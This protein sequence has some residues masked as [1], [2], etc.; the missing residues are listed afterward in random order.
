MGRRP[1]RRGTR[2]READGQLTRLAE[3]LVIGVDT[4]G[5]FT[6]ISVL[7]PDG[8][9]VLNKAPTTPSD[10]SQGVL[11]ALGEV[12]AA[13]EVTVQD[14]LAA[15]RVLKH[16]TT[17]GTNA[18]IT[19]R[20]PRIGFLTTRG[21]E[22]TP[23]IMR[24]VGR[25]DGLP[26]RERKHMSLVRKP[27]PLVGK[28]RIRGVRERVDHA[29]EVV[30]A[31]NEDDVR[32][33]LRHLIEVEQVEAIAV[34]LLF[35]WLNPSHEQAIERIADEQYGDRNLR[36]SYS[37]QLAP[38]VREY[39][40]GNTVLVDAFLGPTMDQYLSSLES[41]LSDQGFDGD[42]M[43]MQAN[44][45]ISGLQETSAIGTLSSGPAGGVMG[46]KYVASRLGHQNVITTDMGGTSF[47]VGL[48]TGGREQFQRDPLADRFRVIQ[49]MI[50]V[51]SIGA[52]GGTIAR[53][54]PVTQRLL[55]GPDSAGAEPG[56]ACY[57]AGG[58]RPTITDADLV[59]GYLD[60][61]FFWGGRRKLD[62]ELA[63]QAIA[64]QVAQPLGMSVT[65]A[66][67]GI[68]ELINHQ[69]SNLIRKKVGQ[70]GSSPERFV[71]YAFGGA[72][73]VH[74]AWY[75]A[76]LGV[77]Q[78]YNFAASP[79][80]SA[81]GIATSD[82]IHSQL[83]SFYSPLPCDCE[84]LNEHIQRYREELLGVMRREGAHEGQVDFVTTFHMRYRGQ[85]NELPVVV[86]KGPYNPRDL[87]AIV[88]LFEVR[89]ED[90]YGKG[91][92]YARAGVELVSIAIDA[93]LGTV[94]PELATAETTAGDPSPKAV[95]HAWSVANQDFV[96][97]DVYDAAALPPGARIAG[98]AI[99][100]API[101]NIVIPPDT[102]ADVDSYGNTVIDLGGLA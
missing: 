100:E 74:C 97:T 1:P 86:Q 62:K 83:S 52:G 49:A 14:L 43:V 88:D 48:I 57:G 75:A 66:A 19:R 17:V 81:Y 61:D 78:V 20:G 10:F 92:G 47:D 65:E 64:E 93:V 15:T 36:I 53:V 82:I 37:H 72:G 84:P 63:E 89:Y 28:Q 60:P 44:G 41:R 59:L 85:L 90:V 70:A 12:A 69:M 42:F 13:L 25:V 87:A 9:V 5:T 30:V 4:G 6:D 54:D 58:R 2:P 11:D 23:L 27:D 96:D 102:H 31:L 34:S 21:F 71:I 26:E 79:V 56:P 50:D 77:R 91:S 40:R 18:L 29:G 7:W 80:F 101:G 68:Y 55:L 24:A 51:E 46:S 45:G 95:R 76:Q 16:G 22:D 33:G 67:A 39:A 8:R 98:P 38:V 73:P 94:K 32:A 35:A 99:V 3:D